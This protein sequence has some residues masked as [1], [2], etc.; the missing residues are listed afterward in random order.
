MDINLDDL[1]V[2]H[3]CFILHNL[4]EINK[5]Q[6]NRQHVSDAL[7]HDAKFKPSSQESCKINN[8]EGQGKNIRNAFVKYFS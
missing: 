7:K 4:C 8:H 5:E 3:A 2:I 6:I 1:P